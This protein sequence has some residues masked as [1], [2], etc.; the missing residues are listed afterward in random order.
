MA[1]S[2]WAAPLYSRNRVNEAGRAYV[3]PATSRE[4]REL[5]LA[6]INNWR[7]S[8]SYPL[9]TMQVGL[10][11]KAR[12]VDPN[13]LVAQRIK[14][15][16]SIRQKLERIHGMDLARM[17][18]IGGCRAVVNT[19]EEVRAV[20]D[21]YHHSKFKHALTREDDYITTPQ[22][23]GYRSAHLIYRYYSDRK[24]TY[25]GLKIEV[26]VRSALQH[27]WATAVETVG[28]FTQQAL[29]A[30]GGEA[31]WLRFFALM[32]S[33]LAHREGT[34]L[35]PGTP[36][37]R[38]DLASELRALANELHVVDR[39]TAYGAALDLAE[40]QT[41]PN[42]KYF[43]L[44]LNSGAENPALRVRGY[45]V[46][47][48]ATDAYTAVERSWEDDPN[49][50][51]V[52]VSV[53]SIASLRRA[54]PNYFLDTHVFVDAVEEATR[55]GRARGRHRRANARDTGRRADSDSAAK[56]GAS[57]PTKGRN[58]AKKRA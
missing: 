38:R 5:A 39:L 57:G 29:K 34:P 3:D 23:T 11:N 54:Y 4:D 15:L 24:T 33:E 8:H 52:L 44:E 28:T 49:T 6:V 55:T 10:R 53:E 41:L 30:R 2:G 45:R 16:P 58:A 22:D 42:M 46:L 21:D 18:D 47:A 20:V 35:V 31:D 51:V 12:K 7:S 32:S 26:Q 37:N 17:Q 40:Q 56:R 27:A 25:N 48:E 19:V 14:R 13:V 9:N 36:G 1:T 50:D 43:L